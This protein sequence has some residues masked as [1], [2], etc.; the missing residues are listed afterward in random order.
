[1]PTT[2]LL[3]AEGE[4]VAARSGAFHTQDDLQSFVD[5]AG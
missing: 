4:L 1:M 3:S 5:Q 2:V